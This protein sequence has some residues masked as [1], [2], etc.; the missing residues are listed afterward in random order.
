V[1]HKLLGE[2]QQLESQEDSHRVEKGKNG[3]EKLKLPKLREKLT[4]H[5]TTQGSK[6]VTDQ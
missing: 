3:K 5:I 1:S 6:L 4:L 2:R